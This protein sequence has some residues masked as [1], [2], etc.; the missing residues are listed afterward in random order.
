LLFVFEGGGQEYQDRVGD[1]KVED[2]VDLHS[3][4]LQHLVKHLCLLHRSRES[5]EH[6]TSAALWRLDRFFN[7]I[8]DN[9]IR[10]KS[11]RVNRFLRLQSNWSLIFNCLAK[12]VTSRKV[13][14][15]VL[16]LELRR[17]R[18]F[19]AARGANKN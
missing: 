12:H 15:A 11:T 5:I 8:Y 2:T 19:P 18:S 6:E 7:N 1:L 3:F 16:L 9:F 13:T 14:Q 4:L 10:H 17:L